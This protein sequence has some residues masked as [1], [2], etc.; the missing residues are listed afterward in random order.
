MVVCTLLASSRSQAPG[1]K[2]V[3]RVWFTLGNVYPTFC[4]RMCSMSTS[5]PRTVFAF[6]KKNWMPIS[7]LRAHG[8]INVFIAIYI[9]GGWKVSWASRPKSVLVYFL[10]GVLVDKNCHPV[11]TT[12]AIKV[13]VL[14]CA[15]T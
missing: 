14:S 3:G 6:Y 5:V 7:T 15:C 10:T 1:R 13:F 9:C 4:N 2:F 11:S 8:K 12:I